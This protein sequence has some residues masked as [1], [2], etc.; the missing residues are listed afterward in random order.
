MTLEGWT[1]FAA[2]S[3]ALMIVPGPTNLV[4][5]SYGLAVG[6]AAVWPAVLGVLMGRAT[7]VALAALGAGALL[8]ASAPVLAALEL[9]GAAYIA[10]V[11]MRLWRLGRAPQAGAAPPEAPRLGRARIVR[12]LWVVTVLN[13]YNLAYFTA[14]MPQ[15]LGQVSPP[16][17]QAAAM[18]ATFL[19]L[20][21]AV[22]LGYAMGAARAHALWARPGVA[23]GCNRVGGALLLLVALGLAATA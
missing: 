2:T 9:A 4:L 16:P 22:S 15:A 8:L 19:G 13:P 11:G 10:W 1:V 21:T 7:A 17:L 3:L 14:L 20:G 23:R 5:L 18:A 6:R 12:H